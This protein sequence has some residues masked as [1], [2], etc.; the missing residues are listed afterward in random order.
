MLPFFFLHQSF[1]VFVLLLRLPAGSHFFGIRSAKSSFFNF[2]TNHTGVSDILSSLSPLPSLIM[3]LKAELET[4]AAALKAYDEQ[5]FEKA[6][7]LFSAIADSS[8]ILT[9]MGLIYATMGEHKLA[10][11]KFQEATRLDQ[12]LA[13]AYFQ[14]GVSNFLLNNF[15]RA[16]DNFDDALHHLRGNQDINY[17]QLGLKFRLYAAEVVFNKGICQIYRGRVQDGLDTMD[18][19]SQIKV[20]E[21]H[22]VIDEAI[23]DRGDGYTV[24]SVPVGVIYRPSEKKLKNVVTKDYLGKAKLVAASDPSDIYTEFSGAA[25]LRDGI[26]PTGIY[27]EDSNPLSRSATVP[28]ANSPTPREFDLV[29]K[30]ASVAESSKRKLPNGPTDYRG[31]TPTN[32]ADPPVP[33][34]SKGASSS[35]SPTRAGK[36]R[37]LGN[38]SRGPST[39]RAAPGVLNIP[40]DAA[41]APEQRVSD[42]YDNYL[43][44]YGGIDPGQVCPPNSSSAPRSNAAQRDAVKSPLRSAPVGSSMRRKPARRN[45]H[46]RRPSYGHEEEEGYGSGEFEE[47]IYEMSK[48]RIKIH[49]RGEVRGMT[50]MADTTFAE[51]MEKV[52]F[53]FDKPLTGLGIKFMDEDGVQVSLRDESD[54]ELAIETARETT[55][56]RSEGKLEIWCTDL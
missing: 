23:R 15:Q 26:T 10:I 24:F 43:D 30:A 49:Y 2:T 11:E 56:G 21:E 14:W 3:S 5:D 20:T 13:I 50:L 42:F 40:V 33:T 1:F 31:R 47:I 18:I 28:S 45:N 41:L 9:N 51:F 8:K 17:E 25:R 52:T 55:R 32:V 44:P 16:Y 48:I 19:A 54:F 46:G 36:S 22:A 38:L 53:K 12:Y 29:P 4:W 6:L 27:L 34:R 7:E 37:G 35:V 39:R